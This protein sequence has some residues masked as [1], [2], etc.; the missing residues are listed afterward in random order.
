[1]VGERG[2]EE[3]VKIATK[4]KKHLPVRQAKPKDHVSVHHLRVS[5]NLD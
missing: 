2:I 4:R 3:V 1:M 5:F